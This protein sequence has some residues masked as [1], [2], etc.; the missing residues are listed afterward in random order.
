MLADD[1]VLGTADALFSRCLREAGHLLWAEDGKLPDV[2]GQGGADAAAPSAQDM[3]SLEGETRAEVHHHFQRNAIR[4][5]THPPPTIV[6]DRVLLAIAAVCPYCWQG[7]S[8][9]ACC[10]FLVLKQSFMESA[11]RL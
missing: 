9:S 10:P 3:A 7:R 11:C 2:A 1:W 8:G 5:A 4:K 6:V